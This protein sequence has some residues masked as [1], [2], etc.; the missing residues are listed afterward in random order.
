MVWKDSIFMWAS[1]DLEWYDPPQLLFTCRMMTTM[2]SLMS[3]RLMMTMTEC[4][5]AAAQAH[6]TLVAAAAG[7]T[8]QE[9]V[10]AAGTT[11]GRGVALFIERCCVVILK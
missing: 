10:M 5:G 6:A 8:E 7:I 1:R 3:G 2:M 11:V 4:L 9:A